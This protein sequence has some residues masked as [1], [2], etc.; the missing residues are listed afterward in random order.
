[1]PDEESLS[2]E[3]CS[4]EMDTDITETGKSNP[5]IT[6]VGPKE[7]AVSSALYGGKIVHPD[8]TLDGKPIPLDIPL[9]VTVRVLS[10]L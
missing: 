4:S 9:P 5:F 7:K 1:M 8:F 6:N 10:H 3:I 2:N